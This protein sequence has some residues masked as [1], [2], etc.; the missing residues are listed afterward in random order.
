MSKEAAAYTALATAADV[1]EASRVA[2]ETLVKE[3]EIAGTGPTAAMHA[4]GREMAPSVAGGRSLD[5]QVS[6]GHVTACNGR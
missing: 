4:A 6:D 1:A 3:G 5:V 2:A